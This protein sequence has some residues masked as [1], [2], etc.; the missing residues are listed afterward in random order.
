MVTVVQPKSLVEARLG[1]SSP[2]GEATVASF[3]SALL[4]AGDVTEVAA[5]GVQYAEALFGLRRVRVVWAAALPREPAS[6][7][8]IVPGDALKSREQVLVQRLDSPD[9]EDASEPGQRTSAL[10]LVPRGPDGWAG[11]LHDLAPNAAKPE[12]AAWEAFRADFARAMAAALRAERLQRSVER[13][14]KA[15][16][17]QRALYAIADMA[18][19]DLEMPEMLKGIH[20]IVGTLMYAEN[21]FIVL[22]SEANQT[23]RFIYF[24][25]S[26]DPISPD[27]D[28]EIPVSEFE[29]SVTLAVI[30]LRR[31]LMGP[32]S[33][34]RAEFN[35]ARDEVMGPD[36]EDWLGVPMISGSEVRG[37]VVV[38]SYDQAGR[39]TEEHRA[40]LGYVAQHILTALE[41]KQHQAELEARVAERTA[42]LG[43]ANLVLRG[44]VQERQRGERLQAALF[45]IAELSSTTDTLEAFY[46]S[47]HAIVGGLLDARN[48]FIALLSGDGSELDFPYSVDERD[49]TRPRRRLAKGLTEF[50]L[51]TARPLLANR[52]DV[53]RLAAAGEV[54]SFGAPSV[55]WLGVP[56][57]VEERAVGVIAVQSYSPDHLFSSRDQELLTFVSYHIATGLVRKRAQESLRQAY[58]ELERR[59][60]ERTAE[61]AET[62]RELRDQIGERER[63]EMR[64]KHQALHDAL[65]GLPN[66]A[67][68]LDRLG[69]ALTRH[70]RDDSHRFGVLFLDLD[71]FKVVNDSVGHLVGDEMLKEAGARIA[72]CLRAPDTVARLGGDEFAILLED[73]HSPQDAFTVARRVIEALS[74]PMRV[75]GKELF[76]S[77]SIGIAIGHPRYT[78]AEE[79]L[80]DADVAM[81][82]AKAK[83]RQRFELFDEQLHTEALKLLDL[84]GDLRRAIARSE[85]E[86]HFQAIVRLTDASVVGYEALLRWR[87]ADR[88]LLLPADFLAVAEEN[89]S[90]EQIDWQMFDLTCREIPRLCAD[91]AYVAINVSARHFRSPD[92]D[93]A[94][95]ALL[96]VRGIDPTR[97]R[98]EVT[99]GALLDNP[100]QIRRVL[101]RLRDA[102]VLSQLD[103]FGTGYSSLSYLHKFPIQTLKIDRSFVADLRPGEAGGSAAVVRAIVTLAGALG[104]E[105]I[106]EGIETTAQRDAL[107]E[108]GCA[109]GQ[110]FLYAHPRPAEEVLLQPGLGIGLSPA[111]SA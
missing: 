26:V 100:D 21:F 16:S 79:L 8:Q 37:A 29:N 55:C 69:Q 80:R 111:R 49:P 67:C 96:R 11:M 36:S 40:L 103:D 17:L 99:E 18:S 7:T 71:R 94:V 35:V 106:A 19:S 50:V 88:G 90:I 77:A 44:E 14:E 30:R 52:I 98:L 41:R 85:F 107:L 102:G 27:P 24:R 81:Y 64:L 72:A 3:G 93:E 70:R 84:E 12:G 58:A 65:T 73:L 95:L 48:F 75:G 86:P 63:I 43:H 6:P 51:R 28:A 31:S 25:D 15:E 82:R 60:Q 5:V 68:L 66:R 108:L 101:Q 59:V 97:L 61:L 89:G 22:Y 9:A 32:S 105:T 78:R 87:H 110:G 45:R 38:Q 23:L 57:M 56:L 42:E 62:N 53:E 92:L 54:Q 39:Y 33:I 20:G 91:G 109:L 2:Q 34:I 47:V 46:S 1:R 104:L 10:S 74:E 83:G 4:R 76:T 13:L